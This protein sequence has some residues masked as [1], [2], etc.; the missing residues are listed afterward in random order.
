MKHK[1]SKKYEEYYSLGSSS[2]LIDQIGV[3]KRKIKKNTNL[4]V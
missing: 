2:S 1:Y 4:L 3:V